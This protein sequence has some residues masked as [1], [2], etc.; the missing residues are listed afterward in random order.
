[1]SDTVAEPTTDDTTIFAAS[2]TTSKDISGTA[3]TK[4]YVRLC[5]LSGGT[6][7]IYSSVTEF[8]FA[9]MTLVSIDEPSEGQAELSW[10][11]SGN[12]N[13]TDGIWW[14]ASI[15]TD[16]PTF[17]NYDYRG[18][19]DGDVTGASFTVV[20]G[21]TYYFRV[22]QAANPSTDGC[23]VYSNI[24][25]YSFSSSLVLAAP[26]ATDATVTLSWSGPT[27]SPLPYTFDEYQIYRAAS[28]DLNPTLVDT[29]SSATLTYD[30]TVASDDTY[31]YFICA[32][33]SSTSKIV[34]YSN[35]KSLLVNVP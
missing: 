19:V 10:T 30:D 29:V 8:T 1:M 6:C 23:I 2:G 18:T 5:K 4:Y 3:G 35:D 14:M 32:Y 13:A 7:T 12:F 34:G 33:N 21:L 28:G 25:S 31:T 27:G 16:T 22:C 9:K 24:L 15:T 11:M 17:T 20:P 26:S